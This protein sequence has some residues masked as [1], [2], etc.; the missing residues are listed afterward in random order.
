[1]FYQHNKFIKLMRIVIFIINLIL[2]LKYIP[3][4]KINVEN[5]IKLV[6]SITILF[7]IYEFY[8]PVVK[9]KIDE[10]IRKNKL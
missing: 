4:Q 8:F 9:I 6:C 10:D 7:L 1:M 3:S 2:I 5:I